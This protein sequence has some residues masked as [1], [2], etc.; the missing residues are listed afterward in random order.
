MKYSAAL[1]TLLI[2]S[3]LITKSE[4]SHFEERRGFFH[5]KRT[6]VAVWPTQALQLERQNTTPSRKGK[7]RLKERHQYKDVNLNA[8]YFDLDRSC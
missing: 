4:G 7:T 3:A 5:F 2:T 1:P 6:K 8:K